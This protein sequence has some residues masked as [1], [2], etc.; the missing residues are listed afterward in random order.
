MIFIMQFQKIGRAFHHQTNF[1]RLIFRTFNVYLN[2]FNQKIA[3]RDVQSRKIYEYLIQDLQSL[4]TLEIKDG[5]SNL[6]LSDKEIK[7]TFNRIRSTTLIRKQREFKLLHG[8]VYTKEQLYKICER[9][10]C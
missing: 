4:Y 1:S 6:V 10:H 5:Q 9:V 2:I 7:E 8:A 3:F